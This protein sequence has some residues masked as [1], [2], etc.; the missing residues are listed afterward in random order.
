MFDKNEREYRLTTKINHLLSLLI[1][2]LSV[3][4]LRRKLLKTS[5][6][7]ERSVHINLKVAIYDSNSKINQF[8]FK[9]IIQILQPKVIEYFSMHSYIVHNFFIQLKCT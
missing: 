6:T 2:R 8:D 7:E 9:Q 5:Y 1:L 3:A 4:S